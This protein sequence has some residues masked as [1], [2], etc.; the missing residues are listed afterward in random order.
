MPGL[1]VHEIQQRVD[2]FIGKIIVEYL[3][4]VWNVKISNILRHR[5][6]HRSVNTSQI[7]SIAFMYPNLV[8][9]FTK[10]TSDNSHQWTKEIGTNRH[11]LE[12]VGTALNVGTI[13]YHLEKV[14][15]AVN[16]VTN[17][18]SWVTL[19]ESREWNRSLHVDETKKLAFLSDF[20]LKCGCEPW[21]L[22]VLRSKMWFSEYN[23]KPP[24]W[25]IC[26]GIL[27]N[28]NIPY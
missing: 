17:R 27:G 14:G 8:H 25:S 16:V 11:T 1:L 7:L 20:W 9:W 19:V 12:K 21:L 2:H 5:W 28:I 6:R 15:T 22:G 10:V 18:H 24:Y 13:R 3:L 4:D 26:Y 23:K